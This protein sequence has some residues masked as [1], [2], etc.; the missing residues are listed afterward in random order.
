MARQS[1]IEWTDATW[2]PS[3]GCTKVSAGCKNCYAE[4]EALKLQN[5]FAKYRDG[6]KFRIHEDQLDLPLRWSKPKMIFVNSMSDLFHEE[7]PLEFLHRCFAVMLDGDRHIYQ[8]L[9]KRPARMLQYCKIDFPRLFA[10]ELPDHIWF[11][12]TVEDDSTKW[13]IDLLRKVP[14]KVRFISFEP[15][16]GPVGKLDLSRISWAIVGGESG[17]HHRI[18][19]PEWAREIRDQA[20][21]QKVPFLFK[22]WSGFRP[23]SLGRELDGTIWDEYPT[24]GLGKACSHRQR[25]NR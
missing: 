14:A 6:F 9:T 21:N 3:T 19:K 8:I 10:C 15:L 4:R 11:G 25:R 22:Q 20:V 2:N 5:R 24:V 12:V 18:M 7:M 17:P 23:K 16:V 13:R 1:L